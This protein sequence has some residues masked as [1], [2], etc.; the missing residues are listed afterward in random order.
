M[1]DTPKRT[2]QRPSQSLDQ[3]EITLHRV[4][5]DTNI[6]VSGLLNR[7]GLPAKFIKLWDEGE[8]DIVMSQPIYNEI[9]EVVHRFNRISL[10]IRQELLSKIRANSEWLTEIPSKVDVI[11]DDEKDNMFLECAIASEVK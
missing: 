10:E 11:K 6:F 4:I 3:G 9:E 7:R 1:Q 8:F 2:S 5:V